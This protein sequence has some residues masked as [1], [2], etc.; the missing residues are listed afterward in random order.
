MKMKKTNIFLASLLV[1]TLGSTSC[2]DSFLELEP[3][4]G[5][6]EANF[7]KSEEDAFL[8]ITS[9]YDAYSFQNWQFPAMCGDI[10]SDDAFCG[11]SGIGDMAQWHEIE[12]CN[13]TSE[14]AAALA[15]WERCYIGNYRANLYLSKQDGITFTTPGLKERMN[16]EALFIRAVMYWDLV[17]H[18]GWVPIITTVLPNVEAY[19]SVPQSTPSAVYAQIMSDLDAAIAG[20]PETVP[21]NEGGRVTKAAAQAL[22]ARIFLYHAGLAADPEYAK[23]ELSGNITTASGK[24]IDKAYVV[25]GLEEIIASGNYA[26]LAKYADVFSWDVENNAES[27][28]EI[29]YNS[30]NLSGW[31]NGTKFNGNFMCNQLAPRGVVA[32]GY[33]GQ[34]ASGWSLGV[35]TWSLY[36]QFSNSDKRKNVTVWNTVDHPNDFAPGFMNTSMF[37]YKYAGR[38]GYSST[39]EYELNYK[40]N[41]I[42]I[43]YADVLLMAA[44]LQ[45]DTKG[46]A[47]VNLVRARAGLAPVTAVDIDVIYQER[48]L[49]FGGEGLRKWDLFRRGLTYA[50]DHINASFAVGTLEGIPADAKNLADFAGVTFKKDYLGLW[51]IPG[52]EI[53][54]ANAG[55][56]KQ[57]VY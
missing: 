51:P 24:V 4:T 12:R 23:M 6:S 49:E 33:N 15:L 10:A 2:S 22:M 37:N 9:V 50:V 28:L 7:Y 39:A 17:R 1:L 57:Y 8:A 53:R 54:K 32:G 52:S 18:F 11:A 14:N 3:L 55:V 13:M 31:D 19:K 27:I 41:F 46:L 43:R 47:Y 45:M 25:A 29:Q 40:K 44:E 42:D 20:L 16:G 35:T 34:F 56:L 36:N 38:A 21:A 30:T 48:R 5:Q 26:L